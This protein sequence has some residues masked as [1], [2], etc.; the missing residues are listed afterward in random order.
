MI[1]II[2]I[3]LIISTL[4]YEYGFSQD[5]P[6]QDTINVVPSQDLW[7][8][9]YLNSWPSLEVISWNLENFPSTGYTVNYVQEIISDLLPDII[10]AYMHYIFIITSN[11][12]Y[13]I[14]IITHR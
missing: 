8:L 14:Y 11:N 1:Y 5:C 10:N 7:N 13:Y 9:E 4:C 2:K 6:P 3:L 12:R